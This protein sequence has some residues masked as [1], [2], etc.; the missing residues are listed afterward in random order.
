[1]RWSEFARTTSV[2]LA[3]AFLAL[4]SLT[5][6][7]LFAFIDWEVTDFME[8]KADSWIL[9]E[10]NALKGFDP[11]VIIQRLNNRDRDR[12]D[13]ERP[14][15]LYDAERRVV[16]GR[17]LPFPARQHGATRPFEFGAESGLRGAPFRGL[18]QGLPSGHIL[19][20]AESVSEL[21]EFGEVLF[22]AMAVAG[23]LT[24][25]FGL[26]GAI[27]IGIGAIRHFDA[28]TRAT[29]RIM[30]GDLSERLPTQTLSGDTGRLVAVVNGMLDEIERLMHEVKGVCD[31][32][33]HDM[34]TP[35]T[36]L[37]AG[38]E[39]TRRR[40]A[41]ETDYA[42]GIDEAID[43]TRGI[44]KTFAALLRISEVED[45]ARRSGFIPVDLA[46]VVADAVDLYEPM[47]E[48]AGVVLRLAAVPGDAATVPGDPG[49]L[50]E[51][52][53]NLIDNAIKF[54]PA[55]GTVAVRIERQ[56]GGGAIRVSDEGP[57]ISAEER[58]HVLRRFYRS[59]RS[60]HTPGNGLGLSL[61][62]AIARLH[63]F[64]LAFS[65][66]PGCSVTLGFEIPSAAIP[67][68]DRPA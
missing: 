17:D 40:S 27:V 13:V 33:A 9:R 22:G 46:A 6:V 16:A 2:K 43:E 15:V 68:S 61:V 14:I 50:F 25:L 19:L 58:G 48:N 12:L 57:G 36:R 21:R 41:S 10:T 55:G 24:A 26:T 3:L 35:L 54:S 8:G 37:L 34:R 1:M 32:I 51:A 20:V 42:A 67:R 39:R 7:M 31:N 30:A 28:V 18:T 62:A 47:A 59:E 56:D 38:L 66:P 52:M 23:G 4:F 65:D 49:L 11:A 5:S 45:G 29:G 60:R 64:S 53:A 63:G 44:L